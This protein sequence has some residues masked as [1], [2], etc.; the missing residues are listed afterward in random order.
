[1]DSRKP[2]S[3]TKPFSEAVQSEADYR[4]AHAMYNMAER[5]RD[6]HPRVSVQ[7]EKAADT[8]LLAIYRPEQ[9]PEPSVVDERQAWRSVRP[10]S[11]NFHFPERWPSASRPH[12]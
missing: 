12:P 1:M 10:L 11:A 8:L 4:Y 7:L 9:S 2:T 5:I 3:A 6:R